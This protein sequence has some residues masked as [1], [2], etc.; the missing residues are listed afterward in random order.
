MNEFRVTIFCMPARF[1]LYPFV[2]SIGIHNRFIEENYFEVNENVIPIIFCL[3]NAISVKLL[4]SSF[5]VRSAL[6]IRERF[7]EIP[8]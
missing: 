4:S 5:T 7:L 3:E 8:L 2:H 6:G 1:V